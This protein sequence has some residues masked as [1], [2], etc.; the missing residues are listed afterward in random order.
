[1][2]CVWFGNYAF[3]LILFSLALWSSHR[4]SHCWPFDCVST[5]EPRHNKPNK[6]SVRPAKTQIS[7]GIRQVWSELLLCAQSVANDPRFLRADS[8]DSNQT[9]LMPRLSWVFAG[10]TLI[11]LA[12][13]CRCSFCSFTFLGIRGRCDLW[14]CYSRELFY[15]FHIIISVTVPGLL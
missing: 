12:L 2:T 3:M 9:G 10:R 6:M 8:E 11:L 1:M 13:S 7:L 15:C 14:L 5:F 4:G